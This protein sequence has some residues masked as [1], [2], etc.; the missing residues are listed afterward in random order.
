MLV[1]YAKCNRTS[2]ESWIYLYVFFSLFCIA[3]GLAICKFGGVISA[4]CC[5]FKP[6]NSQLLIPSIVICLIL[7]CF[8]VFRYL[9]KMQEKPLNLGLK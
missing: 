1:A 6:L 9:I 5:T 7:C 2:H 4:E 8:C 3:K